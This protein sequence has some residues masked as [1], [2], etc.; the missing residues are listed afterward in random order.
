MIPERWPEI[1]DLFQRTLEQEPRERRAFLV[2]A[3]GSDDDL[4][5]EVNALLAADEDAGPFMEDETLGI[6]TARDPRNDPWIGRVLGPY[7]ILRSIGQGGMSTVYLASR[8]DEEYENEVAIK[9]V[10]R[11]LRNSHLLRRFRRERQILADLDH[12]NIAKLHDAG[13]TAEGVPYFVMELIDGVSILEYC[14]REKLSIAQRV[15]LFRQVCAAVQAAHRNLIVHRD[16]KPANILVT[17]DGIPKLLDFGIAKPLDTRASEQTLETTCGAH[18]PM[19]LAYA[20]PEQIRGETLSTATDIYSLGVVL[21]E[22]VAGRHPHRNLQIDTSQ[23]LENAILNQQPR[24]PSVAALKVEKDTSH[25][26]QPAAYPELMEISSDRCVT[27]RQL[28]RQLNG[29]LDNIIL[30]ALR[31]NSDRRYA[32]VEQ[33]SE[34]LLR[35]QTDLPIVARK[36]S[37]SYRTRKFIGRNRLAIAAAAVVVSLVL[38]FAVAMTVLA[39]QISR[40]RDLVRAASQ[41]ESWL[42]TRIANLAE[43]QEETLERLQEEQTRRLETEAEKLLLAGKSEEASQLRRNVEET[44]EAL[45][46]R[47]AT[48]DELRGA[49]GA[50]GEWDSEAL[51]RRLEESTR[52]DAELREA[53][54]Q[55]QTAAAAAEE[56]ERQRDELQ[57]SLQNAQN[58]ARDLELELAK[59]RREGVAC[60]TGEEI[61]DQGIT[62]V[63]ICPGTFTIGATEEDSTAEDLEKPAHSVTLSEFWLAKTE[64]TNDMFRRFRDDHPGE[65]QLPATKVRWAQA[66]KFCEHFGFA[67]P[68]EAEWEVAARAGSETTWSFGN[69][70]E[71]LGRYAWYQHNS[72]DTPRDV[73][74]KEPNAWG[75]HDMHGNVWEWVTD[76]RAPYSAN[77]QTDPTGINPVLAASRHLSSH[78]DRPDDEPAY[79]QVLRGGAFDEEPTNLRSSVRAGAGPAKRAEN[80]GFRCVRRPSR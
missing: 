41:R 49:L 60:Q 43:N 45:R 36:S 52:L 19:T 7:R 51:R 79:L 28:R 47:A 15:R 50:F 61:Q 11:D 42:A 57:Q 16:I 9:I 75:L 74:R 12:P 58:G 31:K 24:H 59:V 37:L 6:S 32:S 40:E 34:D 14:N 22:L 10:R 72:G 39:L 30:M 4:L 44:Q 20:S 64:V 66:R 48:L 8:V 5:R 54:Q 18:R 76:I 46:D 35:H 62:F 78:R 2:A 27:P 56:A 70:P 65:A 53:E 1:E 26:D 3:C 71:E 25:D 77:H 29:D 17:H 23:D 80:I 67:L 33:F 21:Y 63:H 68:T 73:G 69:N 55:R 38:G 13:T